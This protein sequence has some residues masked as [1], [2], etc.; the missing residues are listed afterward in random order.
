MCIVKSREFRGNLNMYRWRYDE[1]NP[2]PSLVDHQRSWEGA[3]TIRK[4]YTQVSGSAG[5]PTRL[6]I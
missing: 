5:Q 4:E 3:E 2:E 1:D 6:M